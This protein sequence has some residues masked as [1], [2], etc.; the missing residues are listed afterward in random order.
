MPFAIPSGAA[1]ALQDGPESPD[2]GQYGLDFM[3]VNDLGRRGP[4]GERAYEDAEQA[5]DECGRRARACL[6]STIC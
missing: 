6:R 4:D 2:A 1:G 3:T 5:M